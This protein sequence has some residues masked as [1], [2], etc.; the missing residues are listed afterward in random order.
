MSIIYEPRGKAREYS[1]LAANF[2]SGCDHKCRYC[3]APSIQFKSRDEYSKATPRN[4]IVSLFEADAKKLSGCR[5]QILFNFMGDPYCTANNEHGITG[6]CLETALKYK[7]PIAI[8]TKGGERCLA[9]LD[10]FKRFGEHIKVGAT[11]TFHNPELSGQWESGAALP[12]NRIKALEALHDNGIKTWAS[13]EP[14][15]DPAE[16]LAMIKSTLHCCDEYKV[17]KLNNFEGL[18]K[19]IDWTSFLKETVLILRGAGK[20]FYVKND[21]RRAAPSIELTER[22]TTADLHCVTPWNIQGGKNTDISLD[23]F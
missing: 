10:I 11:L 17:G 4:N 6:K 13:F 3:Y 8:L 18:D 23:L 2:Y 5:Q 20:R 14:V 22:E 12:E 21:L 16:S 15:I 7:L 1:P 19:Q 9:D